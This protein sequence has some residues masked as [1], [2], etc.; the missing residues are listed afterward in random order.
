MAKLKPKKQKVRFQSNPALSPVLQIVPAMSP[1][2]P[3]F[4]M[5]PRPEYIQ[6]L[7]W[8]ARLGK[9][10]SPKLMRPASDPKDYSSMSRL[11]RDFLTDS[12]SVCMDRAGHNRL[13]QVFKNMFELASTKGPQAVRAAEF[14]MDR[15]WGTAKPSD[16]ELNARKKPGGYQV[17]VLSA[18]GE[19]SK[20]PV[21]EDKAAL[22]PAPDF[23]DAQFREA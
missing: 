4:E 8:V 22:P 7:K 6:Q 16:E 3:L 20:V 21:E 5:L 13:Y 14:L 1:A 10:D 11:V 18:P 15:G 23:V 12:R 9:N 2:D 17:V 19:L